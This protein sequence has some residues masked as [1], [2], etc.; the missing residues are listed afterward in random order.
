MKSTRFLTPLLVIALLLTGCGAEQHARLLVE[1][2]T[3][4]GK[5]REDMTGTGDQL[6]KDG[7]IDLHRVCEMS[8]KVGIDV[9]IINA[10]DPTGG[11]PA[12]KPLGTVIALHRLEESKAN[13]PFLGAGQRLARMGYDV[14]LPDLRAHGRSGGKYVT[15]GAKEKDDVKAVVDALLAEG[16]IHE[17]IY[18]FGVTLGAVTAIQYAA[19]DP[20]CKGVMAMTPYKDFR[21]WARRELMMLSDQD[22]EKSLREAGEL[23]DFDPEQASAVKAA[24]NVT[25]PMFLVHGM[26]DL[27]VPSEHS[28]AIYD[29]AAGPKKLQLITPGPEQFALFAVMEDWVADKMNMVATGGLSEKKE[30]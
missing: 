28:Q 16:K 12:D 14:V 5:I 6:I 13:W 30:K 20:R 19:V 25:A 4:P 3:T 1:R 23:A 10:K 18:A 9:W 7:K 17:P 8:D 15:H 29:A 22:F 27:T 26:I 2:N 24:G 11:R 21:S